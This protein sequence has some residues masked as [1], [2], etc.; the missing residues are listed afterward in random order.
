MNFKIENVAIAS[1]STIALLPLSELKIGQSFLMPL[2]NKKEKLA[3]RQCLSR[4]Q[5]KNHPVKLSMRTI[6]KNTVRI[7]RVEDY[8]A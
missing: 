2:K 8:P 1:F 4:H 3:I 7:G 6:D 5:Q